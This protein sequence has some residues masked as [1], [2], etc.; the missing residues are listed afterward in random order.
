MVITKVGDTP[1]P[2][3]VPISKPVKAGRHSPGHKTQKSIKGILKVRGVSDPA[4]AP[5]MKRA[6]KK[7]TLRILSEKGMMKHKKT[8][9]KKISKMKDSELNSLL[10]N[11]NLKLNANTPRG[12]KDKIVENAVSAGF[13]SLN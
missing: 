13:V 11:S 2:T 4:R 1:K 3:P 9:K 5:P 8:L 6:M 10:E 7:H 12:I